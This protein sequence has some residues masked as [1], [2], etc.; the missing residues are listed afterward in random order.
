MEDTTVKGL[1]TTEGSNRFRFQPFRERVKSVKIDITH[2]I[3]RQHEQTEGEDGSFFIEGLDRWQELN[4]TGHFTLF[5]RDVRPFASSLVQILYHKDVIV[6]TILKHL[7][8]PSSLALEPLLD[9]ITALARDLQDECYCYFPRMFTATVKLLDTPD[10]KLAE[11]VFN[12][13]AYLFKYLAKELLVDIIPTF[14]LLSPLLSNSKPFIRRFAAEAFGSLLRKLPAN[15]TESVYIRIVEYVRTSTGDAAIEGVSILFLESLKQVQGTIH[16]RAPTVLRKLL[17][18]SLD[19][20][21]AGRDNAARMMGQFFNMLAANASAESLQPLWEIVMSE[22]DM[23]IRRMDAHPD[24]NAVWHTERLLSLAQTWMEFRHG[25]KVH[26]RTLIY[27]SVDAL[28][29][30]LFPLLEQSVSLQMAFA[31]FLAQLFLISTS[32]DVFTRGKTIMDKLFASTNAVFVLSFVELLRAETWQYFPQ[33]VIPGLLGYM[34]R[35]W[36]AYEK[37]F[38]LFMASLF[39]QNIEQFMHYIPHSA[40]T[41][42]NLLRFPTRTAGQE[43]DVV[44]RLVEKIQSDHDWEQLASDFLAG[45]ETASDIGTTAA[46]CSCIPYLAFPHDQLLAALKSI[47]RSLCTSLES[48]EELGTSEEV[49]AVILSL[50]GFILSTLTKCATRANCATKLDD[51]SELVLRVLIPNAEC[52]VVALRGIADYMELLHATNPKQATLSVKNLDTAISPLLKNVGS[53]ISE[54]RKHTLRILSCF[55]QHNL[56]PLQTSIFEGPCYVFQLCL[57]MECTPD[58]VATARE[59]PLLLRRLDALVESKTMPDVYAEVPA[60]Y[61]LALFSIQFTPLWAEATKSLHLF[62]EKAMGAFWPVFRESL[63]GSSKESEPVPDKRASKHVKSLDTVLQEEEDAQ[64]DRMD[65]NMGTASDAKHSMFADVQDSLVAHLRRLITF[66]VS[67][68]DMQKYHSLLVRLLSGLPQIIANQS[69]DI[70]PLFLQL[71]NNEA[72]H[73]DMLMTTNEAA[74]TAKDAMQ[75]DDKPT[76]IASIEIREGARPKV[77]EFLAAF[78][79]LRRP[80]TIFRADVVYNICLQLLCKGDDKLQQLALDCIMAW[81]LPGM[82]YIGEALKRLSVD[83]TFRDALATLDM[84]DIYANIQTEYRAPLMDVLVRI[85]Y[86]KLISRRGRTSASGLS[87]RRA[88]IF[89]FFTGVDSSVLTLMI[90]LT[91]QPFTVILEQ[92]DPDMTGEFQVNL[93]LPASALGTLKRQIGF[94]H[95]VQDS[96][97]QLRSLL[98]PYMPQLLKVLLYVLHNADNQPTPAEESDKDNYAEKQMKEV[99]Q[100]GIRRLKELFEADLEFDFSPYVGAIFQAFVNKRIPSFREENTQAPSALLELFLAWA[101][102]RKYAPYLVQHSTDLV[103]NV[104]SVLSAT[105]VRPAVTSAVLTLVESILELGD[106]PQ[107]DLVQTV[108]RPHVQVLLTN[109][110]AVLSTTFAERGAVVLLGNTIPARVIRILARLSIYVTDGESATQLLDMML[111]YTK[112]PATAVPET[113]KLEII[114]ILTNFL[115]ILPALRGC[116]P[117]NTPYFSLASHLFGVLETRE[118]R[119]ALIGVFARFATLDETLAVVSDLVQEINSYS[120]ARMDEPDF[121]R[122]FA[123]FARINQELYKTLTPSQWLPILHNLLFFVQE[124]DEFSIRTSASFGVSQFITRVAALPA[125]TDDS[126][127]E[128]P[129]ADY[130]NLV[131]HVILPAIKRGVKLNTAVVR[132][133]FVNLLGQLV[134]SFPAMPSVSDMTGLLANGDEEASFFSNIYHLQLHRR[135]RALRRLAEECHAKTLAPANVANIFVPIV[136][137]FIF[138][139]DRVTDHN[140]INDAV[141]TIAA[142]AS[143]LQWGQYWALFK[144]FLNAMAHRPELEK[145]LNRV[146]ISLLDGF[147]FPMSEGDVVATISEQPSAPVAT[148][149]MVVEDG[150]AEDGATAG[151]EVDASL[152]MLEE[153]AEDVEEAADAVEERPVDQKP[154]GTKVHA[155]V[156]NKLLPTLQKYVEKQDDNTIPMRVPLALA[157]AKLLQKLPASSM[158]VP[159]A[160]LI[161]TM[162]NFLRSRGQD[163][164]DCTRDTLVKI[165]VLL[166]PSFFPFILK[167]LEGAL[168]RGYQLHVLGFTVHSIMMNLVPSLQPG[169]L[170]PCVD[171]VVRVCVADIF[172][173]A[174][175][176]REVMELRGKM[177]EIKTTKSFDSLELVSKAISFGL[178]GRM[179]LPLKELMLETS[180][181]QVTRKIEEI[182]RRLALGLNNNA[183]MEDKELMIFVHELVTENLPLSQAAAPEKKQKSMAEKNFTVHLKRNAT[184]EPIRYF[185][186]NAYMFIDFGLSLLVTA[187]RSEKV[188]I[189]NPDHLAMLDPLVEVL[190]RALYSKHNSVSTQALRVLC[191]IATAPL[192]RLKPTMPVIVRR[193]FEIL[194]KSFT[195]N[196]ELTK[197]TFRLLTIVIR[198][199]K[200]VSISE[201]QLVLVLNVIRPDLE[202]QEADRQGTAF[203]LIRAILTRKIVVKEMYEL[204]DVVAKIL[205]TSQSAQVRELCRQAYMQF[206]LDYPQGPSRLKKQMTYFIKNLSYD[207][208]SGRDSVLQMLHSIIIKFSDAAL[209]E[210]SDLLFLSLVMSLVNDDVAK[211][212]ELAGRIIRTL[213]PRLDAARFAKILE[214][215]ETWFRQQD[216]PQLQRTAAQVSGL[217]LEAA[218][219]REQKWIPT[220]LKLIDDTLVRDVARLQS[221]DPQSDDEAN[222]W[223]TCYYSLNTFS[224]VV[225]EFPILKYQASAEPIW[226]HVRSLLL[227]PHQWI[228]IVC[229][230]LLGLFFQS[231]DAKT[232]VVVAS[233]STSPHPLLASTEALKEFGTAFSSQLDSHLLTPELATQILKNMVFLGKCMFELDV[234]VSEPSSSTS[235]MVVDGEA[236]QNEAEEDE[237]DAA[238]PETATDQKTSQLLLALCRRLAFLCRADVAN[239]RGLLRQ[240]TFH[241]FAAMTNYIPAT[242]INRYLFH[243]ISTLYRTAKDETAKGEEADKLRLAA[244]EVLDHIRKQ[245]GTTEYLEVYHKVETRILEV[246]RERKAQRSI[247]AVVDPEARARRR[248]QKNDMKRGSRKRK[249]EEFAA[250]KIKTG[251]SKKGRH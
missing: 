212:R 70:V 229:N 120:T 25:E 4:C 140:L 153:D 3:V 150:T 128:T 235:A 196:A 210:Y 60:R 175:A 23:E 59:K 221:D 231:V 127:D 240:S 129:T 234:A 6:E 85:L 42:D 50:A 199:C 208:E 163:A 81:K 202:T 214:L 180:S 98:I 200:Y 91:I 18:V 233:K 219:D 14:E 238:G 216:Q 27:S 119:A 245:V 201:P 148:D 43:V 198:D 141:N 243:M 99:R 109:L 166:G 32:G 184:L 191:I 181:V 224:K 30:V 29:P 118:A 108:L 5:L 71:F 139:S 147:H 158:H 1:N 13:L 55:Q 217:I 146:I 159:L 165:A 73:E 105:K 46:I 78:A 100:L 249:A 227:H 28:L 21:H 157:I 47:L 83:D 151:A 95:V 69:A 24:S 54:V 209:F 225:V 145:V 170:D 205:V 188:C 237:E 207:H 132:S 190:G 154:V 185:Q 34:Q 247:Q 112:R 37:Q 176:E 226:T 111:P 65:T 44:Q 204:M 41:N 19:K 2:R 168:T 203:S 84:Q 187:L 251:I 94:L 31:E 15:T 10:L 76:I 66:E 228:R 104:I 11:H 113:T 193:L 62:G 89:A 171:E 12:T 223:E 125:P 138:E 68:F 74:S 39:E 20:H 77:V 206:L 173:E 122:R 131:T 79:K 133:E 250:K 160:K 126:M 101:K 17:T 48:R 218:G 115:P 174:G 75:D 90:N 142:C 155:V 16:S 116:S 58:T 107:D 93:A 194:G 161:T 72:T 179:L 156:I 106:D 152:P 246:R 110:N 144:R 7:L 114:Q 167:E 195:T 8:V 164:R 213:V 64:K 236:E 197:Q 9:L 189:R 169:D 102:Q 222:A 38:V 248:V 220:F 61:V 35:M 82:D 26:D 80:Q 124:K 49:A 53:V 134:V 22:L 244:Q 45:N 136:A 232:R 88:A 51:T 33:M 97:K 239:K 123:A 40:K 96:I 36:T 149:S 178:T 183:S 186:A 56:R 117:V 63:I 215:V 121:N 67:S 242:H 86:G 211:C 52:D 192:P 57:D 162:C 241:W 87:A 135:V 182:F 103:P 137:H 230:K 172:G 143:A 177:R 92:A 130:I